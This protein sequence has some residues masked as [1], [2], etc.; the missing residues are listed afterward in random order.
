MRVNKILQ[1][2][3]V[4]DLPWARNNILWSFE[5]FV[6]AETNR[7]GQLTRPHQ[8]RSLVEDQL[9]RGKVAGGN[10]ESAKS[11]VP[12]NLAKIPII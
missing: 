1:N 12:L 4:I 2:M 9:T 10:Q 6:A 7:F 3:P 5:L 11:V 8:N